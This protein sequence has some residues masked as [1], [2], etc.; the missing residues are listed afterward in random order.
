MLGPQ[1]GRW[2]QFWMISPVPSSIN[3]SPPLLGH[4]LML[5][6]LLDWSEVIFQPTKHG[7]CKRK[8][9]LGP[10]ITMSCHPCYFSLAIEQ[11][12]PNPPPQ[13][14]PI[15]HMP[16]EQTPRQPTPGPSGAQWLED[17]FRETSQHNE[18]PIPGPIQCSKPQVPSQED[19]LTHEPEPEEALTQSMK[20]PFARPATPPSIPPVAAKNPNSS[21]SPAPRSPQ[22]HDEARQEFT[23]LRPT[24]MIPRA[25]V[26][27]SINRILLEHCQLL[28]MITFVD[29]TCQN[30]MHREFG[31]ELNSLLGQALEAYP[32][33]DITGIVSKFDKK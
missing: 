7:D 12:P 31:E 18:P 32:K 30:E 6:S 29:A 11:N 27:K 17:L 9:E 33:E 21:S 14:T 3:L 25:I 20:E 16:C 15:P 26:H 2:E 28:Y 13:D 23:N 1:T 19:A 5:T 4:H 24:L 8:F 22:S 10:I